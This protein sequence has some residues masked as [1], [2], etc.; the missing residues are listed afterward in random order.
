MTNYIL[1]GH[2][3]MPASDTL[4]WARWFEKSSRK[5]AQTDVDGVNVSTV[6]LGIDHRFG[7]Q[8]PPIVFETMVFG[9]PLDQEQER[10]TTWDEAEQG[11]AAMVARVAAAGLPNGKADSDD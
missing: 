5:V 10:Y 8:G 11:H 1:D 3:V 2:K 6:F 9:G 4:E 7:G